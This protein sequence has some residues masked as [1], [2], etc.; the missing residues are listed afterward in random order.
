[1]FL[2]PLTSHF[3]RLSFRQAMVPKKL[4]GIMSA[5]SKCSKKCW[6]GAQLSTNNQ[7][8]NR[9]YGRKNK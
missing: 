7:A 1:M 6:G 4:L 8:T 3:D 2:G 5:E 9:P